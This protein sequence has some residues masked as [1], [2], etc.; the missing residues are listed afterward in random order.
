MKAIIR[1]GCGGFDDR[2]HQNFLKDG[3]IVQVLGERITVFGTAWYQLNHASIKVGVVR[4]QVATWFGVCSYR[5]MK[6]TVEKR[7]DLCPVCKHDLVDIRYFGAKQFVW[8]RSSPEYKRERYED[9]EEDGR[10]V[11]VEVVKP[12]RYG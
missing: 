11:W 4:F 12:S 8:D 2:S 3:W 1:K 9:Y 10:V 5:K 7:E 6:V